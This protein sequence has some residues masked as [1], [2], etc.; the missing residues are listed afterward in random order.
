[1]LPFQI[2]ILDPILNFI[3]VSHMVV[4][5]PVP[6]YKNV[7]PGRSMKNKSRNRLE[8]E[9]DLKIEPTSFP[10]NLEFLFQNKQL[11]IFLL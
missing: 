7:M 4:R 9:P 6:G 8:K 5:D 3:I 1:M 2:N 10:T 11:H